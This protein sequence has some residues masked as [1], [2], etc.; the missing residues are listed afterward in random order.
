VLGIIAGF[1]IISMS[2]LALGLVGL[3]YPST[4]AG[5]PVLLALVFRKHLGPAGR[6]LVRLGNALHPTAFLVLIP[7]FLA[8]LT[9]E[10]DGDSFRFH[11]PLG[12][13]FLAAHRA[14]ALPDNLLSW[15]SHAQEMVISLGL[16]FGLNSTGRC[17]NT[18]WLLLTG[19]LVQ[20]IIREKTGR[21]NSMLLMPL[22]I[23]TS[24]L[25]SL[26]ASSKNDLFCLMAVAASLSLAISG[27]NVSRSR[28]LLLGLISGAIFS[29]KMVFGPYSLALILILAFRAGNSRGIRGAAAGF[30]LIAT[31]WMASAYLFINNPVFP[32]FPRLF[33]S[34]FF[35]QECL[36]AFPHGWQGGISSVIGLTPAAALLLFPLFIRSGS[37]VA[38]NGSLAFPAMLIGW[39]LVPKYSLRYALPM[40]IPILL[41]VV[42]WA[43]SAVPPAGTRQ[44]FRLMASLV[45][46]GGSYEIIRLA[47][48]NSVFL[49]FL[50][51]QQAQSYTRN[52]SGNY[53]EATDYASE[54]TAGKVMLIGESRKHP[55]F[56]PRFFSPHFY[57]R[58]PLLDLARPEFLAERGSRLPLGQ[59]LAENLPRIHRPLDRPPVVQPVLRRKE[60]ILLPL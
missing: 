43:A 8:M 60:R 1:G 31:P 41:S 4:L 9:P 37:A 34:P 32:L 58:R 52:N 25:P 21:P 16:I 48:E 22:L 35:T 19:M 39:M 49:P 57:N 12:K 7:V 55:N 2:G 17:L 15:Y 29:T 14:A 56:N 33:V 20:D 10:M 51:L 44:L 40:V 47:T 50:G 46:L 11:L 59:P 6:A 42:P 18:A 38:G 53:F 26:A 23:A 13:A 24:W 27:N 54:N 30:A 5:F 45:F 36:D 3:F 28:F